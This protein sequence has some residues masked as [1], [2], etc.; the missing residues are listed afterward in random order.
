MTRTCQQ[1]GYASLCSILLA[2]FLAGCNSGGSG[3]P[4]A[5]PPFRPQ[6]VTVALGESGESVTLRTTQAGGYTRNNRP[7]ASGETVTAEN[8][9]VYRLT[10]ASGRW[11]AEFVPPDPVEVRLGTSGDRVR[12]IQTEDPT[13]FTR[14][15]QAFASGSTVTAGNRNVYRLTLASGRWSAEFVPQETRVALGNLGGSITLMTTEAGGY[16]RNDQTFASGEIV[17]GINGRNYRVTLRANGWV[18]S[19]DPQS[20]TVSL[21]DSGERRVITEAEDGRFL[22]DGVPLGNDGIVVART[23]NHRYILTRLPTGRWTARF[24]GADPV[25]VFLSDS[26]G[27]LRL[28]LGEDGEYRLGNRIVDKNGYV[29][30][31]S[32]DRRYRLIFSGG[33]W[34]ATF[35]PVTV[36][37]MV[38]ETG[39]VVPVLRLENGSHTYD[40]ERVTAG[41]RVTLAGAEYEF[42]GSDRGGWTAVFRLGRFRVPLGTSGQYIELTKLRDGTF[43]RDGRRFRSGTTVTADNGDRYRLVYSTSAGWTSTYRPPLDLS[44]STGSGSGSSSSSSQDSLEERVSQGPAPVFKKADGTRDS[45]EGV[46]LVVKSLDHANARE[47]EYAIRDLVGRGIVTRTVTFVE[48]ARDTIAGLRRGIS[49]RRALYAA[50]DLPLDN[51]VKNIYW[52]QLQQALREILDTDS[53]V[54]SYIG[55]NPP[56]GRLIEGDEIDDVLEVFDDVLDA[57][58]SRS[59]FEDDI[60]DPYLDALT[61][62]D[63]S[64]TASEAFEAPVSKIRFGSTRNTRFAVSAIQDWWGG[65]AAVPI[66]WTLGSFAYSPLESPRRSQ[67]ST[68]GTALFEG[69]TVAGHQIAL[70]SGETPEFYTGDISVRIRFGSGRVT[71][72]ITNLKDDQGRFWRHGSETV[73]SIRLPEATLDANGVGFSVVD[74]P[75]TVRFVTSRP[76]A[77][78]R[79][80]VVGDDD[81]ETDA[82]IGTWSLSGP[83]NRPGLDGAFGAEYKSTASRGLPSLETSP[84]GSR[85]LTAFSFPGQQGAADPQPNSAGNI[86]LGCC[87]GDIRAAN[88]YGDSD[89]EWRRD[90]DG[91][92]S[93]FRYQVE[94]RYTNYTRFGAW[95]HQNLDSLSSR[96]PNRQVAEGFF[97]YS[98]LSATVFAASGDHA[99]PRSLTGSYDGKTIL[100]DVTGT[101][102]DVRYSYEGDL[103]L[104]V[105][106]N[107]ARSNA[108]IQSEIRNLR[109]NSNNARFM[110]GGQPVDR[111][112]L[113]G[114][115]SFASD[116]SFTLTSDSSPGSF[117]VW[118]QD[119]SLGADRRFGELRGTFLGQTS[120][121]PAAVIG[122]WNLTTDA[123]RSDVIAR[124]AYGADLR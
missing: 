71:G 39:G 8:D 92:L 59:A 32:S 47:A 9:N 35:I 40:G 104:T 105:D 79:G 58:R 17:R 121:G 11:S 56:G 80:R 69:K 77:T 57:L 30:T 53:R 75:S 49:L 54:N 72:D 95:A 20:Q 63:A 70:G 100:Y 21:G 23:N 120:D 43:Q 83:P 42:T 65:S 51:D 118:Y 89:G 37:L 62:P 88:L 13:A 109:S 90:A 64:Q 119:G 28:V 102:T 6:T 115:T 94:Y 55:A 38:A 116:S 67:L 1:F 99:Y 34:T 14:D 123:A 117:V 76:I 111:L 31:V 87:S 68:A 74:M 4:P 45:D 101:A 41:R 18:G 97:A 26:D 61:D 7:F 2:I 15:G 73:E 36:R 3:A 107:D 96:N 82:V 52:P 85:A 114:S 5:P 113:S 50:G 98:P 122:S 29:H 12:L 22:V 25:R 19:F 91:S 110:V 86:V 10:L 46:T 81:D 103:S 84:R 24:V 78:F 48:R 124:G 27:S 44:T 33:R 60:F 66:S 112:R 108:R 93:A 106:W 16:T